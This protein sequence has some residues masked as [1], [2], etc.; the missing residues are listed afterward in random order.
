MRN[1]REV[2]V[3]RGSRRGLERFDVSWSV[4]TS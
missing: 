3:I 1:V 2:E 4:S